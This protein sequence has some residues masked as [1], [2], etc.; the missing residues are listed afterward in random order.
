MGKEVKEWFK[1]SEI[2][3][4]VGVSKVSV[5]NKIKT[6]DANILQSLWKREKGIIYY[7]IKAVDVII[8]AFN[9]NEYVPSENQ[10][11]TENGEDNKDDNEYREKYISELE[12]E[13]KYLKE[14]I[15]IKDD[16]IVEHVKLIENEQ[17]L[18][19]QDQQ[20]ITLLEEDRAKAIND[21]MVEWR[22]EH[23]KEECEENKKPFNIIKRIFN[24]EK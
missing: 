8:N 14:Q 15:A 18:R 23:F 7:N 20:A 6:I 12:N 9:Q 2:A 5:Y 17:V 11:E 19:K 21:K 22:E 13:I 4:V 3:K 1:V 24:K 10:D 16:L